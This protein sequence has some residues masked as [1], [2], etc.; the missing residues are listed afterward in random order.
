[1][2]EENNFKD[3]QNKLIKLLNVKTFEASSHLKMQRLMVLK[4]WEGRVV[5]KFL[6]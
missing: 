2:W 6:V 4:H 3:Y 5:K 1:M